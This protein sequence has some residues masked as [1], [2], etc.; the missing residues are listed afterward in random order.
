[1]GQGPQHRRVARAIARELDYAVGNV[2]DV[3]L[4]SGTGLQRMAADCLGK[5]GLADRR[6]AAAG[7]LVLV[8]LVR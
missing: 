7:H 1:M 4:V 2:P 6:L 8:T 5:A 3:L